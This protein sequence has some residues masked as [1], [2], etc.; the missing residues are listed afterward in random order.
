M[1][2]H[3]PGPWTAVCCDV[4]AVNGKHTGELLAFTGYGFYDEGRGLEMARANA[5]LISAAPDLYKAHRLNEVEAAGW[6]ELADLETA[7]ALLRGIW[8]RSR[9]A[10]AKAG[11]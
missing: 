7:R 3:T 4:Q 5:T 6:G 2:K 8:E 11:G 9:A 1:A 10:I